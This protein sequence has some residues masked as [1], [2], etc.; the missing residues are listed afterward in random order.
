[1]K[2][3]YVIRKGEL[4]HVWRFN[5]EIHGFETYLFIRGT[6]S[7]VKAYITS[8]YPEATAYRYSACT[9]TEMEAL[10]MLKAKIYIAPEA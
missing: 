8:E 10:Q 5:I 3:F 1:M 6:E 4:E 9:D 7:E 2:E